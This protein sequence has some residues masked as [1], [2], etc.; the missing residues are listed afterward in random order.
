ME[1]EQSIVKHG[2][3]SLMLWGALSLPWRGKVVTEDLVKL[4]MKTRPGK[5]FRSQNGPVKVQ[6]TEKSHLQR[7]IQSELVILQRLIQTSSP[8]AIVCNSKRTKFVIIKDANTFQRHH[9]SCAGIS[10]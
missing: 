7:F 6:T 5:M 8:D 9:F 4:F 1:N 2:E 10:Y 3:H